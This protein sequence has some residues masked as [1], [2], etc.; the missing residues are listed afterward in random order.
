MA[1][2]FTNL[3][4]HASYDGELKGYKPSVMAACI[5][6]STK[7]EALAY[8]KAIGWAQNMVFPLVN[9]F[10]RCWGLRWDLRDD[11]FLADPLYTPATTLASIC[12]STPS[13]EQM[14]AYILRCT[15]GNY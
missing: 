8:A 6:F 3:M 5:S 11:Q 1:S 2:N 15:E 9:R 13:P 7:R 10:G 4:I 12:R 14:K